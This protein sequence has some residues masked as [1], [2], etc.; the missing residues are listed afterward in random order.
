[1]VMNRK[2]FETLHAVYSIALTG[3]VSDPAAVENDYAHFRDSAALLNARVA[4]PV[5][6]K[7]KNGELDFDVQP[8][9]QS[10]AGTS[11]S[12]SIRWHRDIG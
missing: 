3:R 4:V 11:A 1:M 12:R 9:R 6:Y 7:G 2:T 5:F 10:P 8:V